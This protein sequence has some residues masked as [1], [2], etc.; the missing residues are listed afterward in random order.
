YQLMRLYRYK[1]GGEGGRPMRA[2][3]EHRRIVE[4]IAE[5]DGELAELFMRRHIR[6]ARQTIEAAYA[7][8]LTQGETRD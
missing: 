1:F 5:R 2:L 6:A 4:A 7:D 3:H 8:E